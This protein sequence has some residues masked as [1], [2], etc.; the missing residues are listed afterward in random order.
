[1]DEST[2]CGKSGNPLC[3]LLVNSW[4]IIQ[5]REGG[6][7]RFWHW[8]IKRRGTNIFINRMYRIQAIDN[9]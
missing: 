4:G 5:K 7:M 2:G 8:L 6:E 3:G 1:V 9:K